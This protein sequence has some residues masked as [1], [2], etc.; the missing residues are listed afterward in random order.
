MTDNDAP[1]ATG[2]T[3][4]WDYSWDERYLDEDTV[5]AGAVVGLAH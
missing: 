2:P 3:C 4:S 1:L 5:L